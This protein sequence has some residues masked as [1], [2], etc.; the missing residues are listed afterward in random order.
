MCIVFQNK[1]ISLYNM[2]SYYVL[3]V[4]ACFINFPYTASLI[5]YSVFFIKVIDLHVLDLFKCGCQKLQGAPLASL[6]CYAYVWIGNFAFYFAHTHKS[7]SVDNN[8]TTHAYFR[9]EDINSF[10]PS[11]VNMGTSCGIINIVG[12]CTVEDTTVPYFQLRQRL[13]LFDTWPPLR[14]DILSVPILHWCKAG[15]LLLVGHGR[16]AVSSMKWVYYVTSRF[17]VGW[18]VGINFIL[19]WH[20]F[21]LLYT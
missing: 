20:T 18:T 6:G 14:I 19:L 10:I 21:D 7:N 8:C 1:R 15:G 9:F 12:S 17:I 2:D 16:V 11:T 13:G 3:T 5:T 4:L